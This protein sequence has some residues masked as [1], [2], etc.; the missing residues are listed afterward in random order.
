MQVVESEVPARGEDDGADH[1]VVEAG[2]KTGVAD[3]AQVKVGAQVAP[4]LSVRTSLSLGPGRRQGLR[5]RQ[6]LHD[7]LVTYTI[8]GNEERVVKVGKSKDMRIILL[9]LQYC[10]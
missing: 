4:H 10:I 1:V 6:T 8:E 2:V 5:R 9:L 3:E 7:A